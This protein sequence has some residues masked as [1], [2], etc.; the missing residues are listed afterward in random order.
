MVNG[1]KSRAQIQQ[2][3]QGDMYRY[4]RLISFEI[5]IIYY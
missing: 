4:L 3:K 5:I 1:I 2:N